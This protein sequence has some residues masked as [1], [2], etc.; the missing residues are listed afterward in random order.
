MRLSAGGMVDG[1]RVVGLLGEGSTAEVYLV[2]DPASGERF[3]LKLL[4]VLGRHHRRRMEKE[5]EALSGLRHPN[6]VGLVGM[7]EHDGAPGVLMEYVGGPTLHRWLSVHQPDFDEALQIFRALLA[8]VEAV[9]AKGLVHRDLKPGNVLLDINGRGLRPRIADFG[10]VKEMATLDRQTITGTAMGT[11][12]YMPPEQVKDASRVDHRADLFSLGC[13]LFELLSGS[14]PFRREDWWETYKSIEM[15]EFV[16]LSPLP[17]AAGPYLRGTVQALLAPHA[18]GRPDNAAEVIYLLDGERPD[19]PLPVP[20]RISLSTHSA[21]VAG[22]LAE[23]I[24]QA[25]L[26]VMTGE[27]RDLRG[28]PPTLTEGELE[29]YLSASDG[30]ATGSTRVPPPVPVRS[31][32]ERKTLWQMWWPA[33]VSAGV[34]VAL[35]GLL[36][37]AVAVDQWEGAADGEATVRAADV[38]APSAAQSTAAPPAQKVIIQVPAHVAPVEPATTDPG[39]SGGSPPPPARAVASTAGSATLKPAA[40]PAA[41]DQSPE[42]SAEKP[43]KKKKKRRS[44][45]RRWLEGDGR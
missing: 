27:Q 16:D 21:R 20:P 1:L 43:R 40:E 10:L 13:I 24:E 2:E 18:E 15:G 3:A 14:P 7:V 28:L 44:G 23:E 17:E 35:V 5:V 36:T 34:A 11:P 26:G 25:T 39:S 41:G 45:L 37:L 31:P 33:V 42:T 22:Q 12:T 32:P 4:S 30:S 19:G 6:I 38:E 9:H 8:G 29:P